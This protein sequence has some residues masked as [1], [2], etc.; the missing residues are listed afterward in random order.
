MRL[1]GWSPVDPWDPFLCLYQN[2]LLFFCG[3][4]HLQ[5]LLTI[6]PGGVVSEQNGIYEVN[7]ALGFL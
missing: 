1:G 6:V 5:Q 3:E 4:E 2:S 7:E